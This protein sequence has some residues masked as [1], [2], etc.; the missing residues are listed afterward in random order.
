[1]D[2]HIDCFKLEE[3]HRKTHNTKRMKVL[4]RNTQWFEPHM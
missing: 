1:M 4:P 2:I 3:P